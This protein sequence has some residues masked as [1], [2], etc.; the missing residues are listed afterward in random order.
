MNGRATVLASLVLALAGM[1]DA[2]LYVAL[3]L[4]ATTFGLSLTWVA[5]LLSANR[6]IRL[7]AYSRLARIAE[8]A[9]LR[10]FTIGVAAAG[11]VTRTSLALIVN[12]L[13]VSAALAAMV[14]PILLEIWPTPE[15]A[16]AAFRAA[17]GTVQQLG[18]VPGVGD[19]LRGVIPTNVVNAASA[20]ERPSDQLPCKLS[21]VQSSWSVTLH[22][23]LGGA[24]VVAGVTPARKDVNGEGRHHEH[25]RAGHDPHARREHQS[26]LR[27]PGHGPEHARV[28]SLDL[29]NKRTTLR[30]FPRS[31]A[32]WLTVS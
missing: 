2:L 32:G 25:H 21:S 30:A 12:L 22:H 13:L 1:G 26:H 14:V 23:F 17:L 19:M 9:G 28:A 18:E 15:A 11:A 4:H 6:L 5:V 3:P 24:G 20:G 27:H 16:A 10:R 29:L 31:L 7:V 8:T